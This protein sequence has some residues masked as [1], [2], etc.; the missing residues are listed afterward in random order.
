M[1]VYPSIPAGRRITDALLES[2][3]PL[4]VAKEVT[5][6]VTSSTT[7]QDDNE[8]FL[9]VEANAKY[10]VALMLLHDAGATGRFKMQ[11]TAPT[12]AAMD[13]GIHNVH[14]NEVDSSTTVNDVSMPSRL[15]SDPQSIGGGPSAGTCSFI[16][17]TLTTSSTAGNLQLQWAQ[18]AT[19][20]TAARVRA[21]SILTIKRIA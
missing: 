9:P 7:F 12:G 15:L 2:M 6:S 1:A 18:N 19:D 13:W 14:I 11:F 8:L 17:G 10:R 3:L 20:A 4:E 16:G 5:E 21:G